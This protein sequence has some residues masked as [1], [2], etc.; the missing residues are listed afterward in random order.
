MSSQNFFS[1]RCLKLGFTACLRAVVNYFILTTLILGNLVPGASNFIR[2]TQD[3]L[4]LDSIPGSIQRR[5][6]KKTNWSV[7]L[8]AG[9]TPVIIALQKLIKIIIWPS[10]MILKQNDCRCALRCKLRGDGYYGN[11]FVRF[12][13]YDISVVCCI[14]L[15]ACV[16]LCEK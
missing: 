9:D 13:S 3:Q 4:P 8:K 10:I 15:L 11:L 14:G 6:L 7:F 12:A 1:Y 2:R 16:C 5:D